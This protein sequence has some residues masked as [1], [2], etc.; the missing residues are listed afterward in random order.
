MS[1]GGSITFVSGTGSRRPN[2]RSN[3]LAS[4]SAGAVEAMTRTLAVQLAP[5]RVNTVVPGLIDTALTTPQSGPEREQALTAA[6]NRLP[7]GR[8]GRPEDIAHAVLFA[9]ENGYFT[10]VSLVVDGGGTLV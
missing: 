5:I 6:A 10:G 1:R 4:A 2:L 3:P 7:A 8:L 9:M